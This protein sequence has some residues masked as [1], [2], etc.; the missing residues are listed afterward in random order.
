MNFKYKLT[1]YCCTFRDCAI[2]PLTNLRVVILNI[3]FLKVFLPLLGPLFCDDASF[4]LEIQ[5]EFHATKFRFGILII[6]VI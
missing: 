1:K 6:V 2:T 4:S 5:F 3:F